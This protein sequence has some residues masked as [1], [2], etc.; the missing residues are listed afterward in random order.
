MNFA[1]RISTD[2]SANNSIKYTLKIV[3]LYSLPR[4]SGC[5]TLGTLR[6]IMYP[7]IVDTKDMHYKCAL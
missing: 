4:A 7:I 6:D 2:C 3:S 1:L 5:L